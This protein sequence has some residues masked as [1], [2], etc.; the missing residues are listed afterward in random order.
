MANID[1]TFD[2]L[3]YNIDKNNFANAVNA[4]KSH[5]STTMS[6]SGAVINF[7]GSS[8]NIDATKL[9]TARN[10]FV[11]H[12]RTISGNGS[13][14]VVSGVEYSV[15]SAKVEN[16]VSDICAILGAYASGGG[17]SGSAS[18]KLDG[19][20]SEYYTLAPTTLTF[21]STEPFDEFQ[22]VKIDGQ[23]IDPSQYVL[24]EGSTIITL[25][26]NYLK[27]L[28]IGDHD[29]D[30]VSSNNTVGGGFSVVGPSLNIHGFYYNQPYTAYV[31]LLGTK[32]TFFVR[33][34]GTF[35]SITGNGDV[36]TGAYEIS[37]NS[38]VSTNSMGTLNSVIS[39]D[40]MSIY[41]TQLGINFVLGDESV[42]ADDDYIYVYNNALG[43]Y[44][45]KCIDK[46]K[47]SYGAIKT[48]INGHPTV[49]LMD[50]MF[51]GNAN[52]ITIP[53]IPHSV[54]TIG[55]GAFYECT[56][57]KSVDIPDSVTSIGNA[58][59]SWCTGLTSID[60]PDSVISIGNSAF[61][62]C[63]SLTSVNIPDSVTSIGSFAFNACTSLT[64][65]D[66]PDS[67]TSIGGHTFALCDKLASVVIPAGVTSI[68]VSA[69][70]GCINLTNI[71]FEGTKAQWNAISFDNFALY[72]VPATV[73]QCTDGNVVI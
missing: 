26:V 50:D 37:G 48:G 54:T 65:I 42:V 72:E 19:D 34:D 36:E 6:G 14:V 51:R 41:C 39:S 4:L 55:S 60:I 30:V 13:K 32:V 28:S 46:K 68:G 29:I 70:S 35:D 56:N 16:A 67:V 73:V 64:S 15:D 7:D 27:T 45:V 69:F 8:Y 21:R 2:N 49:K 11:S 62:A 1:V 5:L 63:D 44:V 52:I 53:E 33:E 47:S 23:V 17:N 12:L 57:L 22:Q 40:G 59:F 3:Q 66:I 61:N 58:A 10:E 71:K 24:E 38:I 31:G 25:S 18:G 20:G 9:S 43:G